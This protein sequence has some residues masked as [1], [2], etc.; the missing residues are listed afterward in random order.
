VAFSRDWFQGQNEMTVFET[1]LTLMEIEL[2]MAGF[3]LT[4]DVL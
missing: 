2:M 4:P 1:T 3:G